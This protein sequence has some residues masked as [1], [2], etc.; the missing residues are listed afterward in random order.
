MVKIVH[1]RFL[2]DLN[3][4]DNNSNDNNNDD[5]EDGNEDPVSH[6]DIHAISA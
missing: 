3:D 6:R 1:L 5:S 2:K 4:N